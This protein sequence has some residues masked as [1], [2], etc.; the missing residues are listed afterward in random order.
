MGKRSRA[1]IACAVVAV[2]S[3]TGTARAD[4]PDL[5]RRA[6][7]EGTALEKHGDYTAALARFR[8]S[9]AQRPTAGNRFHIGYCLE[10]T[11]KLAAAFAEYE[12][13]VVLAKEQK[14]PDILAATTTQLDGLRP[15]VPR[16]ALRATLPPGGE[17]LVD[18]N[19]VVDLTTPVPVDPGRHVVTA[20]APE[21]EGF[22]KTV[23]VAERSIVPVDVVLAKLV[24]ARA[25]PEAS[26]PRPAADHTQAIAA[27][28]GAI[29]LVGGGIASFLVAGSAADAGVAQCAALAAP[30]CDRNQTKVRAFDALALGGWIAGAGLGAVAVWLWTS[31]PARVGVNGARFQLEGRF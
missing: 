2:A 15:R 28:A 11:G 9:A 22:K 16:L 31:K 21:H 12:V 26:P 30:T 14:K 8:D 10:M 25:M 29:L 3:I 27:T 4:E 13:V 1:A 19:L 6:F 23:D 7:E 24:I 5:A 17:V 18:G 20:D